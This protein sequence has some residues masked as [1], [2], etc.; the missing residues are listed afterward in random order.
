MSNRKYAFLAFL[1]TFL[2]VLAVVLIFWLRPQDSTVPSGH[3]DE[4]DSAKTL[5]IPIK[6]GNVVA[7]SE[8]AQTIELTP[9]TQSFS[10]T[11]KECFPDLPTKINSATTFVKH[12]LSMNPQVKEEIEFVHYFF[13]DGNNQEFRAHILYHNDKNRPTRELKLYRVLSDGL[14]DPIKLPKNETH[15]PDDTMLAKHIEFNSVFETQRKW[16]ATV[17]KESLQVEDSNQQVTEFQLSNK[18]QVFR[19]HQ[20]ECQCKKKF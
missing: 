9:S 17:Y 2:F 3:N 19:C 4:S 20:K 7:D 11:A 13:K 8:V 12:W 18:D 15:N 6:Q 14:P 10:E 1:F 16:T 5:S